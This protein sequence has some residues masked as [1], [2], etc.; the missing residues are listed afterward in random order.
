MPGLALTLSLLRQGF[1]GAGGEGSQAITLLGLLPRKG[2]NLRLGAGLGM[3]RGRRGSPACTH[4]LR[5]PDILVVCT[6][7]SVQGWEPV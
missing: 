2:Q 3:K 4:S 1:L 6:V 7:R 5:D